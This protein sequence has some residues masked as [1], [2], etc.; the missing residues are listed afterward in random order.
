MYNL[1]LRNVLYNT[2]NIFNTLFNNKFTHVIYTYILTSSLTQR[3]LSNII[4]FIASAF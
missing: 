3:K 2:Q 1:L 4:S